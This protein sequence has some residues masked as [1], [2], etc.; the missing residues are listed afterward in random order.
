[1]ATK[2]TVGEKYY[3]PVRYSENIG[4]FLFWGSG[5]LSFCAVLTDSTFS[6]DLIGEGKATIAHEL[7]NIV[8]VL[9]VIALFV[10]GIIHRLYFLPRAEDARRANFLSDGFRVNLSDDE[11]EGYYNNEFGGS[12]QR[13]AANCMESSFFTEA[14]TREMLRSI[15]LW[16]AIYLVVY[17]ILLVSRWTDIEVIELAAGVVFSEA[18]LSNWLRCE[19]L[20]HR[21]EDVYGKLRAL[22][23]DY[24]T[25][26]SDHWQP[27][28]L[29]I[30]MRYETTKA[31]AAISVSSK[32][33]RRLNPTLSAEWARRHEALNLGEND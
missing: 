22:F 18:V 2:D 31:I 29:E 11:T 5:L 30:L 28:A 15:R 21:S 9:F 8:F 25:E 23:A 4:T 10:Q 16:S 17:F 3:K 14:L 33:F 6:A 12:I 7:I 1:M 24:P 20:R 27:R 13:I 32:L 19:F 26:Q